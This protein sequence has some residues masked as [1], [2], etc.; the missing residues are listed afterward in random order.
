MGAFL[1]FFEG[2]IHPQLTKLRARPRLAIALAI[3]A[4]ITIAMFSTLSWRA[5]PPAFS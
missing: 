5:K 1:A 2:K 4:V 3:V